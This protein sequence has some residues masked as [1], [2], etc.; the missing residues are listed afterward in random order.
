[1]DSL[2]INNGTHTSNSEQKINSET[3]ACPIHLVI[4]NN[5]TLSNTNASLQE[6]QKEVLYNT[7]HTRGTGPILLSISLCFA[8]IPVVIFGAE[9][10]H[11]AFQDKVAVVI[12]MIIYFSIGALAVFL[13]FISLLVSALNIA[14]PQNCALEISDFLKELKKKQVPKTNAGMVIQFLLFIIFACGFTFNTF[15]Y[16]EHLHDGRVDQTLLTLYLVVK[17]TF[18]WTQVIVLIFLQYYDRQLTNVGKV[19]RM[20]IIVTNACSWM[21]AYLFESSEIFE[22]G[23]KSP[24]NTTSLYNDTYE[25]CFGNSQEIHEVI[26]APVT[27]EY[28]MMAIGFLFPSALE[29]VKYRRSWKMT[30]FISVLLVIYEAGVL[31]FSLHV[32]LTC[33][34]IDNLNEI[35]VEFTFYV[36]FVAILFAAMIGLLIACI[37]LKRLFKIKTTTD[38]HLHMQSFILLVTSFGNN[39]YHLLNS[40]AVLELESISFTNKT[41]AFGQ[42]ILGLILAFVQTWFLLAIRRYEVTNETGNHNNDNRRAC[43]AKNS[44]KYSC[45]ALAVMNFGLWTYGSIAEIREPVFTY[46]QHQYYTGSSWN[47]ILKLIFPLTIFYRFHSSMDFLQLWLYFAKDV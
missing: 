43:N 41:I 35:P 29:E 31:G 3:D 19:L 4:T 39:L 7:A 32:V 28:T 18:I 24:K 45:F 40:I 22:H 9:W 2:Q 27:I 12:T 10:S 37:V 36:I 15:T 46:L 14:T 25:K 26:F 1:M 34:A 5:P 13:L 21:N 16:A 38:Q 30:F 47:V 33:T 17:I 8:A 23:Q 11:I 44:L 6:D 42:N 20:I